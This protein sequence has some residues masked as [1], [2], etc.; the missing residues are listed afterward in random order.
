VERDDT[1]AADWAREAAVRG[2]APGQVLMAECL[3]LGRGVPR[4]SAAAETWLKSA[5]HQGNKRAKLLLETLHAEDVKLENTPPSTPSPA[6]E[7]V[8]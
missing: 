3:L 2:H 4:D 7:A 6:P 1:A 5:A 8:Q